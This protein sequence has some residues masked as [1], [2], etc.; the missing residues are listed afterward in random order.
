MLFLAGGQ[1]KQKQQTTEGNRVFLQFDF[2]RVSPWGQRETKTVFCSFPFFQM[3]WFR[4][5][6]GKNDKKTITPVSFLAKPSGTRSEIQYLQS[7][8]N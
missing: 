4:P 8:R 5:P 2:C 1:L 6:W 7:I 3:I